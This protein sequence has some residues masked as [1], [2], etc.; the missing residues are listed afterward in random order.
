MSHN[1]NDKINLIGLKKNLINTLSGSNENNNLTNTSDDIYKTIY[2]SKL[3][4]ITGTQSGGGLLNLLTTGKW[5]SEKKE[6]NKKLVDDLADEDTSS[7]LKLSSEPDTSSDLNMSSEI[8]TSSDLNMSSEI[9]TSSDLNMSSE[10]DT[11]SDLELSSEPDTSSD[12]EL[13]SNLSDIEETE[14]NVNTPN[15]STN[16]KYLIKRINNLVT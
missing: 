13:S 16:V 12:L 3:S 2:N 14:L 9:N 6:D 15:M 4:N 7:D 1:S 5:S 8:N 11:S 10:P